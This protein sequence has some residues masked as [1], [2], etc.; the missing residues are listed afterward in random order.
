M[1]VRDGI[2]HST[3]SDP[4][5]PG[6]GQYGP[7]G[8]LRHAAC[9]EERCA[10]HTAA[11]D[12]REDEY[13]FFYSAN[14]IEQWTRPAGD[15]VD[16]AIEVP[17]LMSRSVGTRRGPRG[18]LTLP[19]GGMTGALGEPR[20]PALRYLV[21]IPPSAEVRVSLEPEIRLVRH[22]DAPGHGP[23]ELP[24]SLPAGLEPPAERWIDEASAASE[25]R[26]HVSFSQCP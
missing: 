3:Q 19:G 17:G 20:L 10:P 9:T 7:G 21:E 11:R 18:L 12:V 15:G 5:V 2:W 1:Y 6:S 14:I 26:N 8:M 13:G 16:L 25:H 23:L 4:A 24:R 22:R